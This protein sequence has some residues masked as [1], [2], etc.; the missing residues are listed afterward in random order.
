MHS[1]NK[2]KKY[3]L[4]LA[5]PEMQL[6]MDQAPVDLRQVTVLSKGDWDR[7]QKQ[8]HRKQIEEEI[9]RKKHAEIEDRKQKSDEMVK[10]WGNTII[11]STA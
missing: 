9:I 5:T 8:L 7:I 11:V 1:S 6:N 2:K 3:H 10:D 4:L